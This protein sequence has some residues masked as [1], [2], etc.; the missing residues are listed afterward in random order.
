MNFNY[1]FLLFLAC[2]GYALA[3]NEEKTEEIEIA[4]LPKTASTSKYVWEADSEIK[5]YAESNK[6]NKLLQYAIKNKTATSMETTKGRCNAAVSAALAAVGMPAW[7]GS[8]AYYAYQVKDEAP[9]LSYIDLLAK[10]PHMTPEEA[11][12]GAILVYSANSSVSC[13]TPKGIGCGHIEFKAENGSA[14]DSK[15]IYYVSDY[16]DYRPV[17]IDKRYKLTAIFIYPN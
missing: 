16:T 5:A 6:V 14:E 2:S 17:T 13:K 11:P 12:K 10:Y 8:T 4:E 7:N 15:N 9:K 3:D 1:I